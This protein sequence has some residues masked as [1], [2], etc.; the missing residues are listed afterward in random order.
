MT[1]SVLNLTN[2]L[3]GFWIPASRSI[4]LLFFESN[5]YFHRPIA[6]SAE[7]FSDYG[8][9][10]MSPARN[11]PKQVHDKTSWN[12]ILRSTDSG[13]MW[14]WRREKKSD[15]ISLDSAKFCNSNSKQ[16]HRGNIEF[17]RRVAIFFNSAIRMNEEVL[18]VFRVSC[19]SSKWLERIRMDKSCANFY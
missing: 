14:C 10:E 7:V 4:M 6:T 13:S 11:D 3:Y 5:S 15:K 8:I 16:V 19:S 17:P 12:S 18:W 1:L 2:F 9:S